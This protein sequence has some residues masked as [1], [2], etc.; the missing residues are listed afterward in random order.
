MEGRLEKEKKEEEEEE[1]EASGQVS[2]WKR[3][4]QEDE[5]DGTFL[6][7]TS[8]PYRP[9]FLH[10]DPKQRVY[11]HVNRWKREPLPALAQPVV[12]QPQRLL[13]AQDDNVDK[14]QI[15]QAC[16]THE[17]DLGEASDELKAEASR[18]RK[19]LEAEAKAALENQRQQFD[20]QLQEVQRLLQDARETGH[21]LRD[22]LRNEHSKAKA[23]LKKVL[24]HG[25]SIAN[26][27]FRS[28]LTDIKNEL[29]KDILPFTEKY[30]GK[31]LAMFRTQEKRKEEVAE[32]A[33]EKRRN[34]SATASSAIVHPTPCDRKSTRGFSGTPC[35]AMA[36]EEGSD[37]PN[38]GDVHS[39]PSEPEDAT[40][41]PSSR[42]SASTVKSRK[43]PNSS[44]KTVSSRSLTPAQHRAIPKAAPV[45]RST[46]G[47]KTGKNHP[48]SK[49]EVLNPPNR[50]TRAK[51]VAKTH[52]TLTP[53]RITTRNGTKKN[54]PVQPPANTPIRPSQKSG[55]AKRPREMVAV[56]DLP[57]PKKRLTCRPRGVL[58]FSPSDDASAA[59]L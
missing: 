15:D 33:G 3:A 32:P 34:V 43:Q 41:K 48:G 11:P 2:L 53:L 20:K 18:A 6:A 49:T 17:T 8:S 24:D 4:Q 25:L 19:E 58:I 30:C 52:P 14:Q 12:A 13:A 37:T 45:K 29:L 5:A 1:E 56:A 26:D 31:W 9:P 42:Q 38:A 7:P 59:F 16:W 50:P 46:H 44:P 57:P 35:I 22:D 28:K 21:T 47:Q 51:T 10:F 23:S 55:P 27:A 40:K 36:T 39:K 54:T